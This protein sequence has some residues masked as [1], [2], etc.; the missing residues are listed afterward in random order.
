[1]FRRGNRLF[2]AGAIGILLTAILHTLGHFS[3]PP[4]EPALLA[5]LNAMSGYR[6]DMGMARPTIMEIHD[7]LSLTMTILLLVV[8]SLDLVVLGLAPDAT[9]LL[10]ALKIVNLLGIAGLVAVFVLYPIPPPMLCFAVVALLFLLSLI[11]QKR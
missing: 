10:H 9:R 11:F 6:L 1:M 4:D 3:S 2:A 7:S 8:G 5:V